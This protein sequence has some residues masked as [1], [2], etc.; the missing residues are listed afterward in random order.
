MEFKWTKECQR[1]FDLLNESLCAQPILRYPDPSRQCTLFTDA[2]KYGYTGILMQ[3]HK[4]EVNGE[5]VTINHPVAYVSGLFRG[6][7]LNWAA[8][9]KEAYGIYMSI[10][11]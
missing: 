1:A 9:T 2:S 7:Q 3:Q 5:M 10:K 8:L 4:T 11:S 6:S